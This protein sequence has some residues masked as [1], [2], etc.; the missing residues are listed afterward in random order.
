[1]PLVQVT[2]L[3]LLEPPR[4]VGRPGGAERI[5]PERLG[6]EPYLALYRR[7]GGPYG[8][9]ARLRLTPAELAATLASERTELLVARG[10]AGEPL[11]FCEHDRTGFPEVEL[12]HFG[13]VAEAMGRG[14]GPRLLE[15]G[16]QAEWRRGATRIW[17][18]TDALD[19]PA[20][21]PLYLRAGFRVYQVREEPSELL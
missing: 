1:V 8:W 17:L 21:L 20:A 6:P 14:L 19:H 13:L 2:Y 10:P 11:G 9:G 16:L 7:V 5:A 15:A 18:H 12:K 4:P 3:E